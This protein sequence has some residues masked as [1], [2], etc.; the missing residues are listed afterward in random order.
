MK[1]WI[2]IIITAAVILIGISSILLYHSARGPVK[3]EFDEAS[4][5][6]LN[7]TAM[8]KIEKTTIYHGAKSYTVVTGEDKNDE[9][10]VAFVPKKKGEIIVRKWADGITKE[11]AVNKLKDEK[12]PEEIL[13][14]RL[15][16]ESVGPVWEITYL[17]KQKN[18]NYFYLLF[19]NGE[20]WKKIEN[21]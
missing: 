1:K 6:V 4:T 18:L 9:K 10:T 5:R 14:V 19:S 13:S 12:Q 3:K 2:T 20:W 15:G 7:E 8:E 11:Q 17:D 21:L 16:H